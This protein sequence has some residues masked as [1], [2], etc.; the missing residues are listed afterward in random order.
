MIEIVT[1]VTA[2]K[3]AYNLI[4]RGVAAK[5]ELTDM[6]SAILSFFDATERFNEEHIKSQEKSNTA[7]FFANQSIEQEAM[8]NAL[9]KREIQKMEKDLRELFLMTGEMDT[10]REF[11]KQR[12]EIKRRRYEIARAAA[13][14]KSDFID[15][16]SIC[17]GVGLIVIV[18]IGMTVMIKNASAAQA[19]YL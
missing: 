9:H 2:A 6:S 17:I 8:A 11:Q 5:Q 15:L 10:Y 12:R 13:K 4:K 1:A 16:V 14:R 18:L 7:K 3:S 19:F